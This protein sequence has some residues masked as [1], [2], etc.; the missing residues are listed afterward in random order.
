M[1]VAKAV[2]S[3]PETIALSGWMLDHWAEWVTSEVEESITSPLTNIVVVRIAVIWNEEPTFTDAD[4]GLR[5][6]S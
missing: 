5:L 6:S 4:E 3:P 2:T 1:P